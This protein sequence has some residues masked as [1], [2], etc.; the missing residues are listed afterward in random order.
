M[1]SKLS[2]VKLLES[3]LNIES[4]SLKSALGESLCEVWWTTFEA[5]VNLTTSSRIHSL[6]TTTG[7]LSEAGTRTTTDFFVNCSLASI[8]PKVLSCEW[9]EYLLFFL[10]LGETLRGSRNESE[11]REGSHKHHRLSLLNAKSSLI[12]SRWVE[13]HQVKSRSANHRVGSQKELERTRDAS[14]STLIEQEMFEHLL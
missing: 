11:P 7:M 13:R 2:K 10:V 3:L 4:I 12:S 14:L 9:K 1:I 6:H 8:I 5:T